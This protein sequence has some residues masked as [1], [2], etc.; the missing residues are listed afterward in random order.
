MCDDDDDGHILQTQSRLTAGL[1][2]T[3][4]REEL[5]GEV[6]DILARVDGQLDKETM[7]GQ[8]GGAVSKVRRCRLTSARPRVE[9]AC[10][11]TA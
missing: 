4:D 1:S 6:E 11:S 7:A 10:L 2:R 8:G 9:S 5:L 3:S